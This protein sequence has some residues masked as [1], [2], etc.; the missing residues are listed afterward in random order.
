MAGDGPC[1]TLPSTTTHHTY[2]VHDA[3]IWMAEARFRVAQLQIGLGSAPASIALHAVERGAPGVQPSIL[4]SAA[5]PHHSAS[6]RLKM[7]QGPVVDSVE[8]PGRM[9]EGCAGC[10]A[11]CTS[12][13]PQ[14][15]ACGLHGTLAVPVVAS[16]RAHASCLQSHMQDAD[17]ADPSAFVEAKLIE[18]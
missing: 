12:S 13:L 5:A 15:L 8:I 6:T 9:E 7:A 4:L 2:I 1:D 18:A 10:A 17:D 16:R 11:N 3:Y 14:R